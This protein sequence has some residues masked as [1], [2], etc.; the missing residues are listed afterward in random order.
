MRLELLAIGVALGSLGATVGA[1]DR[2]ASQSEAPGPVATFR[3]AVDRV[4]VN[5]LVRD[6]RGRV[7]TD[8]SPAEFE[9]LDDGVRRGITDFRS[10]RAPMSVAL[11][12]D[13]SGSMK[14]GSSLADARHAAACILGELEPGVDEIS[15]FTFD[16][17]LR[18]VKGFTSNEAAALPGLL[19]SVEPFGMTSLYDAIAETARQVAAHA[20]YHRGVVVLTD[21]MDN[22][23]RLSASEVSGIASSIDVPVYVIVVMSPLDRPGSST[24]TA[25]MKRSAGDLEDLARWTGGQLFLR[26]APSHGSIA[27][28]KIVEELSNQYLIAFEPAGAPGWHPLE[29]RARRKNLTVRARSGY[30]AGGLSPDS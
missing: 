21:G 29:V 1:S 8:L 19:D 24:E 30:F 28:Q 6:G 17:R 22:N 5:V 16:S 18:E 20:R 26:T 12:L 2:T 10:E 23:S 14:V 13:G 11:L 7:V 15:L 25:A 9:V 4:T 27:A 3:S